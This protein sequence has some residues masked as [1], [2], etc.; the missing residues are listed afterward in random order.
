MGKLAADAYK[1]FKAAQKHVCS[2]PQCKTD[3]RAAPKMAC[4]KCKAPYCSR[5]CQKLHWKQHKDQCRSVPM[6]GVWVVGHREV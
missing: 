6:T 1:K 4:A 3:E 2:N 5:E